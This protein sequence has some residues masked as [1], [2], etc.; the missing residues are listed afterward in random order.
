MRLPI[1]LMLS[2][3]GAA[4]AGVTFQP[5]VQ[6]STPL[7]PAGVVIADF[8]G[9][10]KPDMA[11]VSDNPDKVS[12][13]TNNGSGGLT[14]PVNYQVGSSVSPGHLV[15]A[16][17]DGDGDQDLAVALQD[18]GLVRVLVNSGGTFSLGSS[19]AVGA[20]PRW[21]AVARLDGNSSWDLA[22]ANRDSNN[23]T[24]LLNGGSATFSASTFAAGAE[25]RAVA[26]GDLNGD[27]FAD[28]I[29][30]NHDS[31]NLTRLQNNGSGGFTNVGTIPVGSSVRPEGVTIADLD[32][33]GT[34]DV[35]VAISDDGPSWAAVFL[36]SGGTLG[37]QTNY[38]LS[39]SNAGSI[40]AFDADGDARPE[41]VAANEDS[42]NIS[43]LPNSGTG[44]FGSAT[45]IATGAHPDRI[46]IG[47]L[48]SNGRLDLAVTNRDSNNTSVLLNGQGGAP[49]YP[50]CNADSLLNLADFGC[51]T[52]K[53]ALGGAYADCNTDG[54]RNLADFGCFTTKFALG[55]P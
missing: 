27:T 41:L 38:S 2:A 50:D 4:V 25:P 33:N 6:Y 44:T 55:C 32:G 34:Q 52:T 20:N 54:V 9:D 22:V 15:A 48:D 11:V 7:R 19:V 1:T 28:L 26:A 37:A 47:D 35:A 21:I 29:V 36:N 42:G 10:L 17:L 8:N 13:F 3:A 16:D 39:G 45:V 18:N 51:F 23:V 31:R 14:G 46:G 24:V 5:A 40:Y 49:C 43:V 53:F 30:T 12:V